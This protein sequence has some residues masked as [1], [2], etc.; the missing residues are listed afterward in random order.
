MIDLVTTAT[1]SILLIGTILLIIW[2]YQ[3]HF[4]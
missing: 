4:T 1:I 2:I 3:N